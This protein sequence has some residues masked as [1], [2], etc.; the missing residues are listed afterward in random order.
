MANED[1][2]YLKVE[3]DKYHLEIS[4]S[5]QDWGNKIPLI[6]NKRTYARAYFDHVNLQAEGVYRAR[7]NLTSPHRQFESL[8]SMTLDPENPVS[9]DR[10]RLH[11]D[12]SF[13]FDFDFDPDWGKVPDKIST[14]FLELIPDSQGVLIDLGADERSKEFKVEPS[15]RRF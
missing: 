3:K 2:K 5:V 15:P 8:N 13:N 14:G 4:Q 6:S 7:L 10:Q 12:L 11:W 9:V 1:S